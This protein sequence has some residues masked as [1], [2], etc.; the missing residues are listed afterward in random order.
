[1][2]EGP[3]RNDGEDIGLV[4]GP[5]PTQQEGR[6][7]PRAQQRPSARDLL[8]TCTDAQVHPNNATI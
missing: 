6:M 1:M 5:P 2:E 3:R 7:R 8:D 4:F